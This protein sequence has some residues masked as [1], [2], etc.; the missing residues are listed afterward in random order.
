MRSELLAYLACPDCES[1]LTCKTDKAESDEIISGVL[2]CTEC[3][4]EFPVVRG[5]PRF[6]TSVRPLQGRNADTAKAFGWEWQ[7][8]HELHDLA[9]YRAQFLDWVHPLQPE[10]IRGKVILD[11][12]C[13]MGR[14]SLVCHE[15]GAAMVLAVD[16]GE[17]VEAAR[18]NAR[19]FPR[20]HVIQGDINRL[21]LKR[22]DQARIDFIFSIGVL[23]HLDDPKAGF[24]ALTRHL[25]AD[26]SIFC[27]VYGRE[28]NGWIVNLVNPVRRVLTSHLPRRVLYA[29]SW[30]L[31]LGLHPAARLIYRPVARNP[32]LNSLRRVLFYFDYLAWLGQFGFRHTHHVVFDHLVAPVA[33]YIFR[34]ELEKWFSDAGL[35]LVRMSWRNRNS[36]RAYGRFPQE[37]VRNSD[38]HRDKERE[39][40][41][42]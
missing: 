1:A 18:E 40:R 37:N 33:F 38:E 9:T 36:W 34:E 22:G 29:L 13:G 8:F 31:T 39:E 35:E 26:G 14:F 7:E 2:R 20:V 17:A 30:V 19:D 12:G 21:P 23:H 10:F 41:R 27:W 3:G 32:R 11:A 5:I 24:T 4:Q 42:R 6:V 16:A 25:R 28:N 15:L